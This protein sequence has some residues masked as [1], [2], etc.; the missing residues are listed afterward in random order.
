MKSKNR[1]LPESLKTKVSLEY[2]NFNTTDELDS[3]VGFLGHER[4]KSALEFGINIPTSGYNLFVMGEPGTGRQS[5][6]SRY[7][8]EK[9]EKKEAPSDWCYVNNFKKNSEPWALELPPGLGEKLLKDMENFIDELLDTFPAAFENPTYQGKKASI[10]REFN[11]RYDNAIADVDR[12][13]GSYEVAVISEGGTIIFTPVIEGKAL[14]ETEFA[15][16]PDDI[17]TE[18]L[19]RIGALEEYLNE[20][21]LELPQWKRETSEKI[22]ALNY[23]TIQQAIKPLLKNLERIYQ[24][25]LAVLRYVRQY[26]DSLPR[27]ILDLFGEETGL[28]TRT[29]TDKRQVLET[30]YLP[31]VLVSHT[32]GE[33]APVEYELLP[34]Y[35]N[36]FGR[37]EYAMSQGTPQTHYRLIR[38]GS[39][40]KADGGYLILDAEK[41]LIEPFAWDALKLALKTKQIKME[42]PYVEASLYSAVS[43]IPQCI[44]LSIKIIL[45]GS[46]DIYYQLQAYDPEF[47]E[48]FRVLV[49]FDSY[50][51]R[52]NET[53]DH[54]IRRLKHYGETKDY[55][56]LTRQAVERLIE[57]SLR[58]AEHK[59]RL[60]PRMVSLFEVM[61]EA[62]YVRSA[63]QQD[64][65]G[66]SHVLA[67]M[68]AA[69][70]RNGRIS[71]QLMQEISEGTI[72]IDT[73]G[74][75]TGQINGLTVME[76][77]ETRFGQPARIT[78]TVYSGS[79]GLVDI[80][81]ESELGQAIHSKGVMLLN[82]Y[83]GQMFAKEFPLVMSANIAME[84]SYGHIDGDSA[85]LAE[86]IALMSAIA[87]IP[88]DQGFAVTGSINQYGEVQ[89]IGGV[90]EKIEGFF[91]LC[92]DRGLT[93]SQGCVIPQDNVKHLMLNDD[94]INAVKEGQ[95]HIY[96]VSTVEE[97]LFIL[98]Q[99]E[100]GAQDEYGR[101]PQTSVNGKV[102]QR[103]KTMAEYDRDG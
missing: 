97:A 92:Q 51:Q 44:P 46:R 94:V 52:N 26:K 81:R 12:K 83:M 29:E 22:R 55:A 76:L 42:S 60:S 53:M 17:K 36:L 63:D 3:D 1:L 5:L 57:Y 85:S 99:E 82:G 102:W 33:G 19:A 45:I 84:Q 59:Y 67:A 71:E 75:K 80:E 65:I 40:H 72:L 13:A 20:Q 27:T 61:T 31:N 14:D 101:Y 18:F 37:I 96:G 15:Q 10:D 70:V 54:L 11:S 9:A 79:N 49:D 62:D 89:A 2:M 47:S 4:A 91:H 98:L 73:Q 69:E 30:Q 74:K 7:V 66:E 103:L 68:K 50:I 56:P 35:Q 34:T 16:L 64:Y 23:D 6:V 24:S 88:V 39:L 41:L 77:G 32:P 93:G 8:K 95:F 58:Q 38:P 25:N 78:A 21:L 100:V 90:N 86:L 87:E 43:L 48:L 28:D